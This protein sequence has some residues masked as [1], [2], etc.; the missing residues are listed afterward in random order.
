M[1]AACARTG[2]TRGAAK[3]EMDRAYFSRFLGVAFTPEFEREAVKILTLLDCTVENH[4]EKLSVTPPGYRRDLGLRE[5]LAEEIARSIGY[6]KIPSTVPVLTTQPW[7]MAGDAASVRLGLIEA[8]RDALAR[9]GLQEAVNFA[10]TGKKWLSELG[11]VSSAPVVNPLSEEHEMLVPSLVPGLVRNALD[12]WRLHFGSDV[13]SI[14]LFELRPTFHSKG[15][16]ASSGEMETGV[17]ERWKVAFALSGPRL[18]GGLKRDLGELDFSDVKGVV[19][20]FFALAGL[21]GIRILPASQA[22]NK[23]DPVLK[24]LHP[25]WSAEVLAGNAVAGY[26][27]LLHP[28]TARGIKARAPLWIGEFDWDAISKLMPKAGEVRKFKA[29]PALPPMERDFAL[30]VKK[31]ITADKII[32]GALKAGKPLAKVAKVFD[33]YNGPPV[34]EGMTSVAVRV[35]FFDEGRSL[36]DQETEAAGSRIVDLWKKELGAEL[37]S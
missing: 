7:P 5:D 21:R 37:R 9:T 16:V 32:Q 35:I 10:F 3:I 36:Q 4:G 19:E 29:W 28:G 27:G 31:E 8:A 25:G 20:S 15:A 2:E 23:E 22:R 14:R 11:F 24:L 1:G 30:V 18:A 6:D 13:P 26:F 34:P 33:I 12:N 17:E